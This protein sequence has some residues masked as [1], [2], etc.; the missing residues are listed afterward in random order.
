VGNYTALGFRQLNHLQLDPVLAGGSGG[1]LTC[2]PLIDKGQIDTLAGGHLHGLGQ[3]SHL[4]SII[5]R[6]GGD[7]SGQE[8]TE[9]VWTCF[10]KLDSL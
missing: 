6:R 3:L 1:L 7:V 10:E 5:S 2:I 8:M 4:G 9:S